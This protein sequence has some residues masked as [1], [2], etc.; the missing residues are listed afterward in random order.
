MLAERLYYDFIAKNHVFSNSPRTYIVCLYIFAP[1][2]T[3]L[4]VLA[5]RMKDVNTD[6]ALQLEER[7]AL[8][9]THGF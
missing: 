6:L 1:V 8:K 3:G 4:P 9:S 7:S 2:I 5:I